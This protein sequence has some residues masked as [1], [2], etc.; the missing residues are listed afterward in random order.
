MTKLS[1][2]T[3]FLFFVLIILVSVACAED[4]TITT[5]YPS[6]YG[7]YNQL[8]TNQLT[9]TGNTSLATTS[10]SNV[11]VGTGSTQIYRCPNDRATDYGGGAW[12]SYGCI[13]QLSTD[14]T[15]ANVVFGV[16][17]TVRACTAVG[18]FVN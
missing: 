2:T 5:Y 3:L 9:T 18:L 13:G 16:P 8:T 14:S 7:N 1:R 10:G 11:I 4:I 17:D 15:C 12:A 6:P